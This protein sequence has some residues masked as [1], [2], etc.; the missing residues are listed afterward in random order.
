MLLEVAFLFACSTKS[1]QLLENSRAV[2]QDKTKIEPPF[3]LPCPC[4]WRRKAGQRAKEARGPIY[5]PAT[6]SAFAVT[7]CRMT[8]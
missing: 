6:A 2:P 8:I 4:V 7:S 5:D 1:K 3:L